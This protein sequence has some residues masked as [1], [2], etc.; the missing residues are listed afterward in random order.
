M[1]NET[2]ETVAGQPIRLTRKDR[3]A[4]IDLM[5]AAIDARG[6]ASTMRYAK[7]YDERAHKAA[8]QAA[9]TA[10]RVLY[11]LI[12]RLPVTD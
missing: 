10:E 6:I 3:D 7:P 8:L 9:L 12:S 4:L 5:R 1:A 11:R 2:P